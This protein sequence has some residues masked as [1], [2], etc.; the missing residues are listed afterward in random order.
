SYLSYLRDRI[1]LAHKLINTSGSI[2]IQIS[3][4]NVH[5]VREIL[6]E[7]FGSENFVTNIAFRTK[8]PLGTTNLAGVYDHIIWYAKD[9]KRLKF[10]KLYS[11]RDL[12][13]NQEMTFLEENDGSYRKLTAKEQAVKSE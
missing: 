9:K 3:D 8:L 11:P 13:N 1:T 6:D 2:F 4:E 5:H 12:N 7:I 10:R